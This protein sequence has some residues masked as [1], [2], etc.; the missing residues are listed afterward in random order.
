MN[1]VL[2]NLLLLLSVGLVSAKGTE[3]HVENQPVTVEINYGDLKPAKTVSIKWEN[4]LTALE[5]LQMAAL[6][7]T[8]PVGSHV[9][10][11]A[12][13]EIVSTRGKMAWYY[14]INGESP[15]KLAINQ[16]VQAGD[17]ISWRYVKDVCSCTVDEDPGP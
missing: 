6:V 4:Q 16:L 9:F 17:T 15:G 7:E 3:K 11:I 10:V 12:I 13:D 1:N 5:V 8:H 14:K 2:I